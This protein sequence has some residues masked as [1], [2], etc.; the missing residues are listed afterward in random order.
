LAKA[1]VS[2]MRRTTGIGTASWNR[3][4]I[5]L[6]KMRRGRVHRSGWSSNSG[7]KRTALVQ[8]GPAGVLLTRP[9]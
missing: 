5:E 1:I 8:R 7:T 9:A 4:L 3:S 2:K 6:T